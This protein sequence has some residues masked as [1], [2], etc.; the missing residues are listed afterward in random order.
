MRNFKFKY[1]TTVVILLTMASGCKKAFLNLSPI[2]NANV[3]TFYKT[4]AD[5]NNAVI[6]A[7]SMHKGIYI[8][9][10]AAQAQLDEVR[11]DNT[12]DD[13]RIDLFSSDSGVEWWYWSWDQC[14]RAIYACNVVV[15]KAP[16]VTMDATLQNQYIAEA[17]FLRAIAYFE[18]VQN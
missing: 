11:S 18:L 1:I 10:L 13:N 12:S 9:N 17:M 8:D 15:E 7:Y 16:G 5:I 3:N 4:P 14:Y 2:S 6:A